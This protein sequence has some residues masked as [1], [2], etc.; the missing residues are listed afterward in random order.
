MGESVIA[1]TPIM[2]AF[3]RL[4]VP[5]CAGQNERSKALLHERDR[6]WGESMEHKL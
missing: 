6:V 1:S 4:Q 3:L 2:G 5:S